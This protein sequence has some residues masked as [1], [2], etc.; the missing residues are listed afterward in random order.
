M[1]TGKPTDMPTDIQHI[2]LP[3][4][5][6]IG[7]AEFGEPS[8][9]RVLLCFHGAFSCHHFFS[10]FHSEAVRRNIRLIAPDRPGQ[11]ASPYAGFTVE[12]WTVIVKEFVEALS[13]DDFSILGYSEGGL[14]AAACALHPHPR[15]LSVAIVS[16]LCDLAC[17]RVAPARW[18]IRYPVRLFDHLIHFMQT[19]MM[20]MWIPGRTAMGAFVTLLPTLAIDASLSMLRWLLPQSDRVVLSNATERRA[21]AQDAK[22]ANGWLLRPRLRGQF[23]ETVLTFSHAFGRFEPHPKAR[24]K[25]RCRVPIHVFHGDTDIVVPPHMGAAM[26]QTLDVECQWVKGGHLWLIDN[27]DVV[28]DA[29]FR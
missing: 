17:L 25:A 24:T 4:G 20:W 29:L 6:L 22:M 16:G 7:Y 5:I 27:I 13:I 18:G 19:R 21:V 3:S 11:G 9:K 28:L 23:H 2:R 12:F 10:L 14:F 15:L 26:A 8:A 1:A